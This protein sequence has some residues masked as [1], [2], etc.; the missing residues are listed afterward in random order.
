MQQS[1]AHHGKLWLLAGAILIALIAATGLAVWLGR[2]LPRRLVERAL[3]ARLGPRSVSGRF[4]C[5][6]RGDSSCAG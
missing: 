4:P 6:A 1:Q 5:S 3:S 2:D